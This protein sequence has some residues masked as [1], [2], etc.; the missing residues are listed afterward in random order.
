M[1]WLWYVCVCV[2]LSPLLYASPWCCPSGCPAS[3]LAPLQAAL[4]LAG[5]RQLL[6]HSVYGQK[7]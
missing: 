4:Y 1:V 2:Q 6:G 5:V 3:G 7:F